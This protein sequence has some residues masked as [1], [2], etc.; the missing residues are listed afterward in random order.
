[1]KESKSY[2]Y[3]FKWV[4]DG[5]PTKETYQNIT[6]TVDL[7]NAE[8]KAPEED[9][10]ITVTVNGNGSREFFLKKDEV[11]TLGELSEL[12]KKAL[13]AIKTPAEGYKYVGIFDEEGNEYKD[14]TEITEDITLN[15][16]FE[17][18]ETATGS[19]ELDN[20]PKTGNNNLIGFISIITLI[21]LASVVTLKK[22]MQ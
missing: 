15:V 4:K 12:D 14:D 16:K 20:T 19:N 6:F 17:K 3:Y 5:S 9:N 21:S 10:Y 7:T 11:K 8:L 2:T 13:E 22:R 1:M 18:I